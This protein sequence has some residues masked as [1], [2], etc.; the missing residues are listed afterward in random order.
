M[1]S[2]L[3]TVVVIGVGLGVLF[4]VGSL[5]FQGYIYTEPSGGLFWQ[6]PA[7]AG[8]LFAFML[9]WCMLVANSSTAAPSEVPYDTILR[10]NP[11]EDL[12]KQPV[13]EIVAI[14]K[15]NKEVTYHM[16]KRSDGRPEY[17]DTKTFD[18]AQP[19][20]WRPENV[21]AIRLKHDNEN[22]T[23]ELQA[24]GQGANRQFT[25]PGTGY[26]M[27]EYDTGPTGIP[28]KF[29]WGRFFLNLFLNAFF[30]VLWFVCLWL[31]LRYQWS[32]AFGL[33]FVFWIAF[34]IIIMPMLLDTAAQ[35]SVEKRTPQGTKSAEIVRYS[36]GC[37]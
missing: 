4:Y 29:R 26:T 30:F 22:L 14:L 18:R 36:P 32:H 6:A 23:F 10:F 11:K 28:Y 8:V 21:K 1:G 37:A 20:R 16:K 5:F 35:V 31:L 12:T 25:H 3:L 15:D 13:P 2:L 24:T 19:S 34:T 7:A 17:L 27:V 33:A 9:L